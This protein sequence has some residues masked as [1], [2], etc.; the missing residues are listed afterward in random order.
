[1]IPRSIPLTALSSAISSA[2]ARGTL[3]SLKSLSAWIARSPSIKSTTSPGAA[4]ATLFSTPAHKVRLHGFFIDVHEVT[5]ARYARFC[6]ETGHALPEFWGMD[7]YHSGPSYPDHPV[8]G[9]S[10]ADANAYAEWA[11][12]RLPTEAE[13]EYAARGGLAGLDFPNG[14]SLNE[15]IANFSPTGKQKRT[16]PVCSYEK[17]GYGLCDMAGN[18]VEWAADFYS[19]DYY[20]VSPAENPRGPADGRFRVIRGGGWHS[21]ASCNRVHYRNALPA[22]WVDFNVGFRCVKDL[23]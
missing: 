22:N 9:V 21:G 8:T 7:G 5:N 15:K 1:M 19:A 16:V 14:S 4:T 3:R 2:S 23:P 6:K 17:N 11:G 20:R 10:W 18:V 12:K 13:W